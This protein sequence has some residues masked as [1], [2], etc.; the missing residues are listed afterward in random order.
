MY[1]QFHLRFRLRFHQISRCLRVQRTSLPCFI[2]FIQLILI[3]FLV[4]LSFHSHNTNY[5]FTQ[6]TAHILSASATEEDDCVLLEKKPLFRD[7]Q[8]KSWD[9]V[10]NDQY[11][12]E[13][14]DEPCPIKQC[15][16]LRR[17]E[18]QNAL[19]LAH[20]VVNRDLPA[21][22]TWNL[23]ELEM[24]NVY[25]RLTLIA[26]KEFKF[27]GR[28]SRR[29]RGEVG[30]DEKVNAVL[31]VGRGFGKGSSFVHMDTEITRKQ[32]TIV[33]IIVPFVGRTEKL[34]LLLE[35]FLQLLDEGMKFKVV[36]AVT[37]GMRATEN[38][39][40][41]IRTIE[42]SSHVEMKSRI[43]VFTPGTDKKGKFSR[44]VSLRDAMNLLPNDALF[45][46]IDVDLHLKSQFF[47][48]CIH[49]TKRGSLVYFPIMYNLYPY[50]KRIAKEHGYWRTGSFGM[51]C[52]HK[53]DF[54]SVSGF[55]HA[56]DDFSG[57]GWED[58]SLYQKFQQ[59]PDMEVFRALEPNLLHR[60][61]PKQCDF[62]RFVSPC[63]GTIYNNMGSHRF[64]ATVVAD[65]DIDVTKVNYEP[66]GEVAQRN[67][68]AAPLNEGTALKRS[69]G[70]DMSFEEAKKAY[71]DDLEDGGLLAKFAKD[72]RKQGDPAV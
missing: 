6:S 37:G 9:L 25:M 49:N 66:E 11:Y 7:I 26:G 41:L 18:I 24:Q 2:I 1:R 51:M 16:A 4:S 43:T 32:D 46:F 10:T 34:K 53:S 64:L 61:H 42:A 63:I 59:A 14:T 28:V 30:E 31:W 52:G 23:K 62:N 67:V 38:V 55:A 58:V 47:S 22:K 60:W 44:A 12:R 68:S 15:G 54:K 33:H 13:R 72:A 45:A 70:K 69:D 65:S 50:G 48:N 20:S 27:N 57:W 3:L 71:E 40:S 17:K 36:I 21:H 19:S 5:N 29:A 39:S 35:N 56:E 8:N